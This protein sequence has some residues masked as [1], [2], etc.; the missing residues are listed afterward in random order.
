MEG[1]TEKILDVL[2]AIV[3]FVALFGVIVTS[4]A[5]VTWDN[6]SIG[7]TTYNLGWFPFVVILVIIVAVVV[8]VYRHML[9][10]KK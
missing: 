7:G 2:L 1:F 4:F 8:L 5:G 3:I 10:K 9:H 6:L